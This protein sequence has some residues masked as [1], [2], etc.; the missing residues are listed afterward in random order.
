MRTRRAAGKIASFVLGL[1]I[2]IGAPLAMADE[3]QARDR[4]W[5]RERAG[6]HERSESE[7]RTQSQMREG[8]A[9]YGAQMMSDEE[10]ASYR[11]RMR[12]A[13]TAQ[14]RDQIRSEHHAEMVK[15]ARERGISLP[16]DPPSRPGPGG[17]GR[18]PGYGDGGMMG[19][20]RGR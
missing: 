9:I 18:G 13:T 8:D 7:T 12:E 14:Q 10:R 1:A 3:D 20:G 11:R 17:M 6:T 19:G 16:E 5:D 4:D 15:R 2:G